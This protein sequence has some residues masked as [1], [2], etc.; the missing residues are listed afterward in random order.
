[1]SPKSSKGFTG[2]YQG[3]LE[4]IGAHKGSLVGVYWGSNVS[5]AKCLGLKMAYWGLKGS[6]SL[7][8]AHLK[9]SG[10]TGANNFLRAKLFRLIRAYWCLKGLNFSHSKNEPAKLF[11]LK[12]GRVDLGKELFWVPMSNFFYHQSAFSSF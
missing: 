4:L 10:L 8:R 3:S 11:A 2:A 5:F 12:V 9:W 7:K 1:M 6:L